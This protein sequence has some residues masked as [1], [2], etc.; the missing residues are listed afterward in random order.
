MKSI[1]IIMQLLD[2]EYSFSPLIDSPNE[3]LGTND[4][5]IVTVNNFK[6]GV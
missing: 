2:K 3:I 6:I 5:Q 4:G 1:S